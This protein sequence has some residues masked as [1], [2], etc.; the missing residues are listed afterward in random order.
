MIYSYEEMKKHFERVKPIR[1]RAIETRPIDARRRDWE[2]IELDG[3][4]IA[5][6]LYHT[7]VVRY[8][9]DGSVGIA[10]DGWETPTTVKFINKHSPFH[11][12]K[13]YSQLWL[14]YASEWYPMPATQEL[15]LKDGKPPDNYRIL[16]RV[17]NRKRLNA[18]RAP[19]RPFLSWAQTFIALTGGEISPDT[20]AAAG[21]N[22]MNLLTQEQLKSYRVSVDIL[23]NGG[24]YIETLTLLTGGPHVR[25]K[26]DYIKGTVDRLVYLN[27]VH[28]DI[29]VEATWKPMPNVKGVLK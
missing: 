20:F 3:D 11:A 18:A 15:I 27:D 4:V 16:K 19:Y 29:E 7:Q 14:S 8:Y 28:D 6:K 24:H 23:I 12:R 13:R 25:V 1:G 22:I 10:T 21:E 17:R 9:P 2:L 5:C 26:F